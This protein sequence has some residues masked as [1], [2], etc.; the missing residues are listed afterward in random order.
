MLADLQAA[1][2]AAPDYDI[3][4]TGHSL[5]GAKALLS[6]LWLSLYYRDS[7]PIKAV[8]AFEA[9]S[10]GSNSFNDYLAKCVG[11]NKIVRITSSN[12]IIPWGR[13]GAENQFSKSV[14]EIFAPDPTKPVWKSCLGPNDPQCSSSI[15]CSKK[16]WDN[17]SII[18]GLRLMKSICSLATADQGWGADSILKTQ[19]EKI[20]NGFKKVGESLRKIHF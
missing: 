4:I 7:L 6:S 1:R 11:P 20:A 19:S 12:D 14:K 15:P 9:P 8:Y 10:T 18:G 17:H 16:N 2:T 3:V 13:V 5:G